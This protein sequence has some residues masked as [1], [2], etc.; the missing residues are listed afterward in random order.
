M[1]FLAVLLVLA[2]LAFGCFGLGGDF[3]KGYAELKKVEAKFGL[4]DTSLAPGTQGQLADLR[5]A[6]E[7]LKGGYAADSSRAGRAIVLLTESRL[8]MAEMTEFMLMAEPLTKNLGIWIRDCGEQG[9]IKTARRYF[10]KAN[11]KAKDALEK[12]EKFLSDYSEFAEKAGV[13]N[14]VQLE[15]TLN[16]IMNIQQD[17]MSRLDARC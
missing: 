17:A 11:D 15:S 10:A 9:V 8:D 7:N 16:G 6:L 14:N 2:V 1:R 13:R 12:R 5:L 3:E 4:S